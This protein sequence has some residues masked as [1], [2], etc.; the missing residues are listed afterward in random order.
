MSKIAI[1]SDSSLDLTKELL[2]ENNINVIPF[3]I[4]LGDDTF[5]DG[6]DIKIDDIFNYVEETKALPKT[7]AINSEEYKDFFNSLLETH[8]EIILFCISSEMSSSFNNAFM[9]IFAC[10]R[11]C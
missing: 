2:T 6:V 5:K 3:G 1:C 10:K 4:T 8:D 9:R 11:L 7:N